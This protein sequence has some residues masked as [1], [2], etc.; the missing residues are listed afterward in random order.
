MHGV[1]ADGPEHDQSEGVDG[2]EIAELRRVQKHFPHP[3]DEALAEAVCRSRL[4]VEN[5]GQDGFSSSVM[6]LGHLQ[7]EQGN[8]VACVAG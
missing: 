7:F 4:P 6:R 2:D 1:G 5:R 8:V 3:A